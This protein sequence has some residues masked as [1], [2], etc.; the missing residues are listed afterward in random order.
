M[1]F[2]SRETK[3]YKAKLYVR[4]KKIFQKRLSKVCVA[5]KVCTFAVL[6]QDMV[7]IAQLVRA[8]DCGSEG[9]GFDP[10]CSPQ[11]RRR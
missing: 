9:R 1:F 8:S 10:H 3:V 6:L 11:T 4:M 7:S 2:L 5:K